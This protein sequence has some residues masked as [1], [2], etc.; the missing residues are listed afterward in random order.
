ML[1]AARGNTAS[2][3]RPLEDASASQE[4]RAAAQGVHLHLGL[5]APNLEVALARRLYRHVDQTLAHGPPARCNWSLPLS[6]TLLD[7]AGVTTLDPTS[8][9]ALILDL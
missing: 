1:G 7:W 2:T 8:D 4:A 6:L 5:G 9:Q 3:F